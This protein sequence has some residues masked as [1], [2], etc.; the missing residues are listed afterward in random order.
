[1][2]KQMCIWVAVFGLLMLLMSFPGEAQQRSR[3]SARPPSAMK[4]FMEQSPFFHQQWWIGIKGGLTAAKAVPQE[5]FSVFQALNNTSGLSFEKEYLNHAFATPSTMIGL[6]GTYTFWRNFSVSLQPTY[7]NLGFGYTT[8]YQWE[9]EDGNAISLDQTHRMTLSYINI[10]VLFRYDIFR[11]KIRPYVQAGAFY[12]RMLKAEK[13]MEVES[14]DAAS[15]AVD[16]VANTAPT[17]GAEDLFIRTNIGWLAG[18]GVNYDMG[19]LRLGLEINY[20]QGFKNISDRRNRFSD[21]RM[22]GVGD[23][24]DDMVLRN[25]EAAITL[26]FP[27]KFLDTGAFQPA[28]P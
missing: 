11:A 8:S 16:P 27:L 14:F 21:H 6:M 22:T 9:G 13:S 19:S 15:G 23:V 28:Q 7:T 25:W 1:M 4:K 26:Q 10:P 24:M 12:G 3:G 17:I 18:A 5:R 2:K 20:Q